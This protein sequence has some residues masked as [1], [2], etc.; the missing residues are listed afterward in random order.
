M[1]QGSE[2]RWR[3]PETEE[4]RRGEGKDR[5]KGVHFHIML[6]PIPSRPHIPE[7]FQE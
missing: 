6:L 1:E 4:I 3:E 7:E 2:E 5:A